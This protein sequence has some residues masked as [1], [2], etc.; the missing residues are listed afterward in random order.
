[1]P[2]FY[3]WMRSSFMIHRMPM[4]ILFPPNPR[5][6]FCASFRSGKW[7]RRWPMWSA[8]HYTTVSGHLNPNWASV[9]AISA[10]YALHHVFQD[11]VTNRRIP[12]FPFGGNLWRVTRQDKASSTPTLNKI[13]IHGSLHTIYSNSQ[14]SPS[15]LAQ[16]TMKYSTIK[17]QVKWMW[18][19][20]I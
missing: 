8:A 14:V 20:Q 4:S 13:W 11:L 18:C 5:C 17:Y 15:L 9:L 2:D 12:K 3:N 6:E 7:S 1:M 19:D 10:L 16:V